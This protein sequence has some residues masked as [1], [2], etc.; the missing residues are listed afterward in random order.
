MGITCKTIKVSDQANAS[1]YPTRDVDALCDGGEGDGEA[2]NE[3]AHEEEAE[4]GAGR[5]EEGAAG[6]ENRVHH[7]RQAAPTPTK[8]HANRIQMCRSKLDSLKAAL[9][10]VSRALE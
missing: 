10:G 4:S 9:S 6:E 7:Y 3:A 5:E 1:L 8:S 2:E